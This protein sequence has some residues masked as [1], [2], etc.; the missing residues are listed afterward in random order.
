L[1]LKGSEQVA[2]LEHKRSRTG[3][4]PAI[5]SRRCEDAAA[6][7]R[8]IVIR[9]PAVAWHS[10]FLPKLA[11]GAFS[12]ML[13]GVALFAVRLSFGPIP[14]DRFAPRIAGAI[15]ERFGNGY[16]FNIGKLAIAL[17]GVAPVLSIDELSMKEPA[18]RNILTAPRA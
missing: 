14:I 15:G 4:W 11:L 2:S 1:L 12:L 8:Q 13:L 18:G 3:T 5:W 10:Y 16:K 6:W 17:D 7:I 9:Q